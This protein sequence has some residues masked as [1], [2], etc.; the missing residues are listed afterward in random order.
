MSA[1]LI[2]VYTLR[3]LKFG[4]VFQLWA[5]WYVFQQISGVWCQRDKN[6]RVR[7]WWRDG[8]QQVAALTMPTSIKVHN[9]QNL[10]LRLLL[11]T[12]LNKGR[13]GP[14]TCDCRL[15]WAVAVPHAAEREEQGRETMLGLLWGPYSGGSDSMNSHEMNLAVLLSRWWTQE[16]PA[17]LWNEHELTGIL[18]SRTQRGQLVYS[19]WQNSAAHTAVCTMTRPNQAWLSWLRWNINKCHP[20]SS[21]CL[22]TKNFG[23]SKRNNHTEVTFTSAW[24]VPDKPKS[25][26]CCL[27]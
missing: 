10:L 26:K 17:A 6:R 13:W 18:L 16:V 9:G 4:Y 12:S 27:I 14:L 20:A 11:R 2:N 21:A 23:C 22:V 3:P 7:E 15:K 5:N 24:V 19:L 8:L 1:G 25:N